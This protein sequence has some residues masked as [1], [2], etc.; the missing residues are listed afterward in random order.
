M[1]IV[2]G[3][4]KGWEK[5]QT[6]WNFIYPWAP[7]SK[8]S[9]Y[10]FPFIFKYSFTSERIDIHIFLY[11]SFILQTSI[12]ILSLFTYTF[13]SLKMKL[14]MMNE[15]YNNVWMFIC[16]LRSLVNEYLAINGNIWKWKFRVW[17]PGVHTIKTNWN[18]C[19]SFKDNT[20]IPPETVVPAFSRYSG[21]KW[22]SKTVRISWLCTEE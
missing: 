3:K 16:S 11:F 9:F 1:K 5:Y 17:S 7:N 19:F 13:P 15:K 21:T 2:K 8:L 4:K 12:F 20:V 10:A 14:C 18:Q 22:A 6:W